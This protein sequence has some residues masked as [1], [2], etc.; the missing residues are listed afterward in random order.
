MKVLNQKNDNC[1]ASFVCGVTPAVLEALCDI[2][3]EPRE[4]HMMSDII[5]DH[6]TF[7]TRPKEWGGFTGVKV[8]KLIIDNSQFKHEA[9]ATYI[10]T[11]INRNL[12]IFSTFQSDTCRLEPLICG[13]SI[14]HFCDYCVHPSLKRPP[15]SCNQMFLL[16]LQSHCDQCLWTSLCKGEKDVPLVIKFQIKINTAISGLNYRR[17]RLPRWRWD[18]CTSVKRRLT[19]CARRVSRTRTNATSYWLSHSRLTMRRTAGW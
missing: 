1:W 8:V 15:Y 13:S 5:N 19:T 18:V 16:Q 14:S 17:T 9:L 12:Y 4:E 10:R 3:I 6:G 11:G 2:S 7:L